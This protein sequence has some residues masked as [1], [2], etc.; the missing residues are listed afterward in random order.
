MPT[1]EEGA[2]HA[3][4]TNT[5]RPNAMGMG[6]NVRAA[7]QVG[8]LGMLSWLDKRLGLRYAR[9]APVRDSAQW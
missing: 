4:I 3:C 8:Y 7:W 1:H 9:V 2:C 5:D 6:R